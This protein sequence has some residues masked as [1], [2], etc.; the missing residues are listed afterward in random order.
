MWLKNIFVDI[1]L[2]LGI[3]M[4][5]LIAGVSKLPMHL[6]FIDIVAAY[7][8]LPPSLAGVYASTLPWLEVT[9]GVCLI[10]G[11]FIRVF[12]V[13]SLPITISFIV[14]NA[15]A[16]AFRLGGEC[17][18]FGRLTTTSYEAALGIDVF[19][20][21]GAL[22]LFFQRRHFITLD[23]WLIPL[24]HKRFCILSKRLNL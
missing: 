17:E 3:G 8:I 13:V 7:R 16:I 23:S 10:L 11:L 4:V 14:A 21:V 22:L 20:L 5:F 9:I 12:S 18:C 1:G 19:L 24:F 15:S 2:R 6:E